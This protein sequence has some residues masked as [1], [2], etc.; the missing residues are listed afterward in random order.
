MYFEWFQ[1]LLDQKIPCTIFELLRNLF[2]GSIFKFQDIID[3]ISYEILDE[4][5]DEIMDKILYEILDEILN[6]ILFEI[7]DE[8][9]NEILYK[10]PDETLDEISGRNFWTNIP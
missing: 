5:P 7:L 10:I 8:F 9:I 1:L 3:E 2:T 6:E 4:I